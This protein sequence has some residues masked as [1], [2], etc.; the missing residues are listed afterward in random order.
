MCRQ[1]HT[2]GCGELRAGDGKFSRWSVRHV[3]D[4]QRLR[5]GE[6]ELLGH[7]ALEVLQ[8]RLT[9]RESSREPQ[10]TQSRERQG[11]GREP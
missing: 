6:Q 1:R 2:E 4:R 8:R 9:N 5:L 11:L 7:K 10:R 3:Q